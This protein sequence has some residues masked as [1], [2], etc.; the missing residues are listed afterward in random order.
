MTPI[1][2]DLVRDG[3]MIYSSNL[4][5]DAWPYLHPGTPPV[6]EL[7]VQWPLEDAPFFMF[8]PHLA[9][10]PMAMPEA[11]L[12]MWQEEFLGARDFGGMFHLT[13]HPQLTGHPSRLRMLRRLVET[14]KSRDD[15]WIATCEDV[16]RHRLDQV[17]QPAQARDR[18]RG[19]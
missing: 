1:T 10:R 4:M 13:L 14:I 9:S 18:P 6:V 19:A 15:V 16:A 8:N 11:V 2:L 5:D 7:P 12:R 17:A 3:G